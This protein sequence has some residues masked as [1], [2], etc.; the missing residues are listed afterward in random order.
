MALYYV[1]SDSA[2]YSI[3][4]Y[5][6]TSIHQFYVSCV[7]SLNRFLTNEDNQ[8]EYP[9]AP[10][11]LSSSHSPCSFQNIYTSSETGYFVM[12]AIDS[13]PAGIF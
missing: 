2:V 5:V 4:L 7:M 13:I 11:P 1:Y 8:G 6:Y 10:P 3:I 9:S 12:R